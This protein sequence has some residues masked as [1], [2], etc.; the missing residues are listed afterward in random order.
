M[1]DGSSPSRP[2]SAV[3]LAVSAVAV[4]IAA[5]I[6]GLAASSA[7][8]DY[9]L[10]QQPSW[11]PPA[12]LFGPAWTLLYTLMA[13]AAWLVWRTGPSPESRRALT[14]YAVQLV[15]NAS[16]TPLFFGLGWRGFALV[17]I[18]VLWIALVTTVVLFWRRSAVAGLLLVPYLTWTTFALIL[19]FA[20]WQLNT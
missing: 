8:R 16:W 18:C 7:T 14:L 1:N 13:I 5:G 19:N 17:E 6:G 9:A 3:A 2:K 4:I 15:L 20:V 11:A 12:W 10:L